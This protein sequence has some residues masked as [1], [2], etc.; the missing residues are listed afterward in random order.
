MS[1]VTNV[2]RDLGIIGS[3]L[4]RT[5]DFKLRI[6]AAALNIRLGRSKAWASPELAERFQRNQL[7][8][9]ALAESMAKLSLTR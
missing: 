1:I 7:A 5:N 9:R 2:I 6:R 8:S 3:H 4:P